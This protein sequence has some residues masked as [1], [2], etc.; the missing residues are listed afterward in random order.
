MSATLAAIPARGTDRPAWAMTL[1][2]LAAMLAAPFLVGSYIVYLLSLTLIFSIVAL[3]LNVLT[4]LSG[5]ISLGHA[6]FFAIG[7]YGTG[8]L[9]QKAGVPFPISLLA[10]AVIATAIGAIAAL[11]A[12]RLKNLYLAIATLGLGTVIQ[13]TLFEWQGMTG[14]GAGL[15]LAPATIGPLALREA[16]P[17]YYVILA[18]TCAGI[19]CARNIG[20][21][22]TGRAMQML[23]ESEVAAGTLA[24][25]V[26]RYKVIAFAV[27]AFY[28]AIAGGLYAYLVRYINPEGFNTGLS[29]SFLSMIVIGGLGSVP[30]SII[31]AAFYVALPELF[32]AIKDAPGLVFGLTL[33]I[34][35][36]FLPDGLW[37]LVSRI[38]ER[39]WQR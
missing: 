26:A 39:S 11:P 7:A 8:L 6:G 31:G 14:G 23:R 9:T 3:G 2:L 16:A 33:I 17:L 10:G 4:G 1:I 37:S 29:I 15:E 30:G 5:Q 34:V 28:A 13:K 20:R 12:L 35:M 36:V 21:G 18:V 38:R 27:S 32:R 22:R 19:W 24:I 25:P